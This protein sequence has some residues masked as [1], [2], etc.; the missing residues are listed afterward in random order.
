[1]SLLAW[2]ALLPLLLLA[3]LG[4][5][6]LRLLRAQAPAQIRSRQLGTAAPLS[7]GAR[8]P[9]LIWSYWNSESLPP[10]IQACA[11]NWRAQAPDHELRF[12]TPGTVRQWLPAGTDLSLLDRLPPFRQA[13]WLRLQLLQT[14]G[15]LWIDASTLLTRNLDWVHQQQAGTGA[16]FVGFYIDR[17]SNRPELPL[18]ENWFMAAVPGSRF[19]AELN[20]EFVRAL[21][22]GEAAY[23]QTLRDA[24]RF[25][26]V[27]Q[28]IDPS[29]HEYLVMH[30]AASSLL[31]ADASHYR[32]ALQ[33]AEDS[34]FALQQALAWKKRHLYVRLALMGEPR[35]VPALV[36]LRGNDR[37]TL[38]SQLRK[39][40]L[41]PGSL[42]ARYLP[43]LPRQLN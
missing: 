19:V 38:E 29:L 11:D 1:M 6:L 28:A 17:L 4:W 32:L 42:L 5:E 12:L 20:A 26:R 15:G 9:R 37:R 14:H 39:R 7:G 30:A 35:R 34:A 24:G 23:L 10:L 16:E 8:I 25:E 33:R 13:D 22:M 3:L 31:D 36:K 21:A 27:I 40:P 43:T 18:V 41:R 2:L